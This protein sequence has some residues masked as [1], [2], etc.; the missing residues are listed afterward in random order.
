MWF[1]LPPLLSKFL[2][3]R[4]PSV[5]GVDGSHLEY[6]GDGQVVVVAVV[7]GAFFIVCRIFRSFISQG[8]V[9][10]RR[11]CIRFRQSLVVSD[12]QRKPIV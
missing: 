5:W 6:S 12:A 4:C 3:S 10:V 8:F 11:L 9:L 7:V 1:R 2:S